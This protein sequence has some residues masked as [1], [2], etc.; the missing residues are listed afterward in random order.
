LYTPKEIVFGF[1]RK[2]VSEKSSLGETI[3]PA[4]FHGIVI[5][6]RVLGS[7]LRFF[8]GNQP[9]LQAMMQADDDGQNAHVVVPGEVPDIRDPQALRN[10]DYFQRVRRWGQGIMGMRQ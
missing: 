1:I 5:R 10:A 7:D 3:P 9:L 4:P 6:S 2:N 8:K